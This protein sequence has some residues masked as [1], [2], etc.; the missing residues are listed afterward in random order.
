MIQQLRV[1]LAKSE[2][3]NKALIAQLRLIEA[4]AKRLGIDPEELYRQMDK[5]PR[6]VSY[7]GS[8]NKNGRPRH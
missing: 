4:N 3:R 8:P 2:T 7:A 5:P 1:E 6:I